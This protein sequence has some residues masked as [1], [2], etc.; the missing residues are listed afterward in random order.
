MNPQHFERIGKF[1]AVPRFKALESRTVMLLGLSASTACVYALVGTAGLNYLLPLAMLAGLM[2][3]GHWCLMPSC[4]S[5]LFG[6]T[7]FAANQSIM[8]LATAVG[9]KKA[10]NL[11]TKENDVG[12][13][14]FEAFKNLRNS[15]PAGRGKR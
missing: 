10:K 4:T 5:E 14:K 7:H 6:A 8:H 11:P 13:L 3:G 1:D 9:K 12:I 2:F 15:T